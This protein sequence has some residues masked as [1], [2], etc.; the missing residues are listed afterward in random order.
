[1]RDTTIDFVDTILHNNKNVNMFQ[2]IDAVD[3]KALQDKL[4]HTESKLADY[5]NQCQALKQEIKISNKV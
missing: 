5:R 3:L 1:M 2:S 4:K